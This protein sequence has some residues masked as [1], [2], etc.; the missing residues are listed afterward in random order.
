MT[1]AGGFRHGNRTGAA[2][3]IALVRIAMA[4]Q[5]FGSRVD[6]ENIFDRTVGARGDPAN[7]RDGIRIQLLDFW[8]DRSR[9]LAGLRPIHAVTRQQLA[10]DRQAALDALARL[11]P[12]TSPPVC[13]STLDIYEGKRRGFSALGDLVGIQCSLSNVLC[14]Y[15]VHSSR[16]IC[17]RTTSTARPR[18]QCLRSC[19]MFP[20]STTSVMPLT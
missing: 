5:Q 9:Y 18:R 8:N 6:G 16:D 19:R 1:G 17:N 10:I 2:I 14:L 13:R 11:P 3:G 7:F 20:P 12:V 4:E 15:K